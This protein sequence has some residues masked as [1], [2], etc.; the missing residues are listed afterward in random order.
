[1]HKFD[2]KFRVQ[3]MKS[4]LSLMCKLSICG[5]RVRVPGRLLLGEK[6]CSPKEGSVAHSTGVGRD[7]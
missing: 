5:G 4:R 6:V 1:M 7:G 3:M 2:V